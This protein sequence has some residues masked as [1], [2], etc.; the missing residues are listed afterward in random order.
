[1]KISL[2][3][4]QVAFLDQLA[5]RIWKDVWEDNEYVSND[6]KI[7]FAEDRARALADLLYDSVFTSRGT[8]SE[9]SS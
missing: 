8:G 4:I 2:G 9:D 6:R 5:D 1:M 3:R 7:E